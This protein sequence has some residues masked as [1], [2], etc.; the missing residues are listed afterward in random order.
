MAICDWAQAGILT[1]RNHEGPNRKH[2]PQRIHQL[3]ADDYIV[4]VAGFQGQ[5]PEGEITTWAVAGRT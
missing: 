3:L 4:V 2:Q 1:D 5:T